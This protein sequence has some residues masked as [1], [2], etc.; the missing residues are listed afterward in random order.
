VLTTIPH[1]TRVTILCATAITADGIQWVQIQHGN[2]QGWVA[3]A[4][5]S[6]RYLTRP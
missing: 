1:N 4:T 2:Q 6:T 5:G 3:E